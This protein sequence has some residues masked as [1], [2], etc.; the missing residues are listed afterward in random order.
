M[1]TM[2]AALL[3]EWHDL[4]GPW[5]FTYSPIDPDGKT[6]S[7][8]GRFDGRMMV[9]GYWD[10]HLDR[11]RTT[12]FWST[13]RFNPDFRPVEFPLGEKPPDAALPYLLGVG[14]YRK[15]FHAPAVWTARSVTLQVGGV[16]MEAWVWLNGQLVHHHIGH[17]TPFA[18]ALDRLLKPGRQNE[19]VIAVANTRRDRLGCV[20]RGY[21]G[22]SAGIYRPVRLKIAGKRQIEDVY[23]HSSNDRKTLRWQ[24]TLND[25]PPVMLRYEMRDDGKIIQRGEVKKGTTLWET[26]ARDIISWSDDNP[27][28][29]QITVSAIANGT[30][31]DSVTQSF[32]LRRLA[33]EGMN[34]RLNGKPV[35]LRGATEHAYFPLTCTPPADPAAYRANIRSL[36]TLGFNWLRFHTWVPSE[37]YMTAADELGLLLQVEP[38][39][40]F[41]EPEW[42]DILRVCRKHPS[43]VIYCGGNEELLDEPRIKFL[44]SM[45]A[46]QKKLAPDALFNP[47]EALH[48]VEYFGSPNLYPPDLVAK[49]YPHSPG[50]L[51]KLKEFSDVIGQYSWGQLSY[52]SCHGNRHDLDA[53][54]KKYARP[55]LSH[56]IGIHGNYLNLDLEHRY[57]G[58]RIG[59]GLFAATRR[60]LKQA[61]LLHNAALYY[62]NSCLWMRV[63]RKQ[64]VETARRCTRL[65]GYDLLGAVDHH[66]HRTGY[67]CGIMNEFYEMKPGESAADVRR[68]NGESVLLLDHGL[69]RNYTAGSLF[70]AELAVS[71]FGRSAVRNG[72]LRWRLHDESGRL[73]QKRN[74]VVT[75]VK[76]GD[77]RPLGNIRF[78]MPACEKAMKLTLCAELSGADETIGNEWDFW[79]FPVPAK[80][81]GPVAA[82]ESIRRQ[83]APHRPSLPKIKKTDRALRLVA[84][85]TA[86][87]LAFLEAGGRAILFGSG[88]LP[89]TPTGFQ[90]STT[91]RARGNLATVIRDHPVMN[92]FPHEGF[93][94]WQFYSLLHEGRAIVFDELP[95]DPILEVV[96]SFKLILKQAS[97]VEFKVGRGQLFICGL[98]LRPADPAAMFLL[99]LMVRYMNGDGLACCATVTAETLR[100]L[101]H[102][103]S[104][105]PTDF[106]TDRAADINLRRSR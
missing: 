17:S 25:G 40:S 64:A 82:D 77:V 87:T 29:Y 36:K 86:E 98:N 3:P 57:K 1:K 80:W 2:P 83:F 96:S 79:V 37:E 12:D 56:E 23:L 94:D 42:L 92:R 13:A 26:P 53:R 81:A 71:F 69:H 58:T 93:C 14:W 35:F 84:D 51:Q 85:L 24:V 48:G 34:L 59:R 20:I 45:A 73:L 97:L 10:D 33:C 47:Q 43:V 11:L 6:P 101:I 19:L 39:C 9:P 5:D 74:F 41:E 52:D 70:K 44:R 21:A 78:R 55:C 4:D 50:R 66:W 75:T 49:P 30:V 104:G 28:L 54:L 61:G 91:G 15:T 8:P 7:L 68:Y 89:S 31:S 32:G 102:K 72:Q 27:R 63:L 99:Q 103:P 100:R 88:G 46:L 76:P 106:T 67:P 95:F 22:R 90:L 62:R 60:Y 16:V 18:V 38:P 105:L 65:A